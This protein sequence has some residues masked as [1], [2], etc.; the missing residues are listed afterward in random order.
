MEKLIFHVDV[1]N[2]YLSWESI[3]RMRE[4]GED[5]DLRTVPSIVGGD[6]EARHGIVLAKSSP[7]KAYGIRT[8][9]TIQ[10][11][12]GKCP[13]L[14]I[15]PPRFELYQQCS[16]AFVRILNDFT[17]DIEK[18]SV[19]EAY[20]DMTT[21]C[22]LFG[23]PLET[24][25]AL[26]TRIREELSFTVN[27]GVSTNKLL[28]KMASD[29]QKPDRVHTLFP[30]EIKKKMW[31]LPVNELFFVG[32]ASRNKMKLLGIHTIGDLAA[33][34]RTL[35]ISHFGEKYGTL[36]HEYANGIAEDMLEVG[37]RK[38][39]GYGCS[40]TLPEDVTSVEAACQV[41]LSLSETVGI[42]L[43]SDQVTCNS[44]S[45]EAKDIDFNTMS[46]QTSFADATDITNVI[47]ETA[48]RLLKEFWHGSPPL[49]LLGVR[50]TKISE[51]T[52]QQ[53]SLFST[54]ADEK[55]EKLKSL[56]SCLD[57]IR[58]KYGS[59]SIKRASTMQHGQ[60]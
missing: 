54:Q 28:A 6:R 55:K 43:R 17:P 34:D 45:V 12:L 46:H 4:L 40:L 25:E 52:T 5:L 56:D 37:D 22:H 57:K 2:A 8:A 30:S 60:D 24:A 31:P 20:L 21:T 42:R 35:L 3:Y 41:L 29:F 48:C 50:A 7:A 33:F 13:D 1:N 15:V 9:E 26:K 51:E 11:A 18:V 58:C 44:I 39:K 59:D 38:N 47:Y 53:L 32:K 49:R 19:D 36:I 16:D 10:S 23:S 14:L 27:V